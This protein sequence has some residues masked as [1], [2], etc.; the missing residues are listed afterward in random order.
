[1]RHTWTNDDD[2]A[3]RWAVEACLPLRDAMAGQPRSV[4]WAA[5]C[6]RLGLVDVSPDAARSRWGRLK[7]ARTVVFLGHDRTDES[8]AWEAVARQVE[9]YEATVLQQARDGVDLLVERVTVLCERV[10]RLCAIAGE[11]AADVAARR[12]E[13][14]SP[15]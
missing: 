13:W 2:T 9:E 10:D 14:D 8:D 11:T 12:R 5:V 4:W 15:Q 7:G 1:M 6:G 3:L